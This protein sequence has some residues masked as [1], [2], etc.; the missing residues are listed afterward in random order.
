M[1]KAGSLV[2]TVAITL[3]IVA[4]LVIIAAVGY[5]WYMSQQPPVQAA[6]VSELPPVP[7]QVKP[8]P[9][10]PGTNVGVSVQ[11]FV[12]SATRGEDI[13]L[14]IKTTATAECRA[15]VRYGEDKKADQPLENQA[16]DEYGLASWGWTVPENV[17]K[18]RWPITVTCTFGE[19]SGMAKPELLVK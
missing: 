9:P 7:K 12:E 16:A 19:K 8:T 1:K 2:K 17:P 5:T 10:T 18:G 6:P 3:G 11:S 4:V 14:T 13:S 15:V